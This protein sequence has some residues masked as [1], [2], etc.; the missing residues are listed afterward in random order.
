SASPTR[1]APRALRA[2]IVAGVIA[3]GLLVPRPARA[4]ELSKARD[5]MTSRGNTSSSRS[6]PSSSD[7][8]SSSSSSDDDGDGT[9]DDQLGADESYQLTNLWRTAVGARLQLPSR[10]ELDTT[11]SLYVE[12][13]MGG[14]TDAAWMG[15]HHVA[16]RFAQSSPVQFRGGLGMRN[17]TDKTGT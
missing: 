12:P 9:V 6:S 17:W 1:F 10:M 2:H 7:S 5:T 13:I 4:N 3:L 14:R 16:F 8:S 15:T 11:W